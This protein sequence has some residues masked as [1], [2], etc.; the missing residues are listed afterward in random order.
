MKRVGRHPFVHLSGSRTA[1]IHVLGSGLHAR[2]DSVEPSLGRPSAAGELLLF[3]EIQG[4][5]AP[6]VVDSSD[7]RHRIQ[8]A[9][10]IILVIERVVKSD[11]LRVHDSLAVPRE[12]QA[13]A[14]THLSPA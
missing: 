13:P 4:L 1:P 9:Y 10:D 8:A 7:L 11:E 14:E 12:E 2:G 5:L 6:R 3:E